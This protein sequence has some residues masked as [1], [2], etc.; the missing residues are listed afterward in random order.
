[1]LTN[2]HNKCMFIGL[3][4]S[5]KTSFIGALWHVVQSGEIN[6]AYSVTSQPEDREYLNQLQS[7]FLDCKPPDRTKTGFEKKIELNMSEKTTGRVLDFIFPDLSGETYESQ[8]EYRQLTL[9]YVNQIADSDCIM[10]FI[11]PNHLKRP[12]LISQADPM[13]LGLE[14][15]A[16]EYEEEQ[17]K[18]TPKTCQTQVIL[19]DLL[20]MIAD[21]IKKPCKVGI[22]ISAW[23]EIQSVQQADPPLTPTSWLQDNLPLLVQYLKSNQRE[24]SHEVFGVSAQGGRYAE[25]GDNS[26]LQLLPKQS[27]RIIVQTNS[28]ISNDITVPLTWLF[29]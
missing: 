22:I 6:A 11:N 1:M 24:F 4:S 15:Q 3:P 8:F 13:L 28:E 21:R 29:N 17:V 2:D 16:D 20:Q 14:E 18:W 26:V 10:L 23:D 19:V 9:E 7:S 5:G 12:F 25:D 27:E